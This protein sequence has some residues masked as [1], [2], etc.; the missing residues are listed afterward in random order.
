[1][2]RR[3]LVGGCIVRLCKKPANDLHAI[4]I[5][6]DFATDP[7]AGLPPHATTVGHSW[8]AL[9]CVSLSFSTEGKGLISAIIFVPRRSSGHNVRE[10]KR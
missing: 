6:S 7:S 5:L 1:M 9:I 8:L 2:G 10:S 3:G 4:S